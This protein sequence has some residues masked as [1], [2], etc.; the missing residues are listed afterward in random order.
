MASNGSWVKWKQSDGVELER[1]ELTKL[2]W[3]TSH[4]WL[5]TTLASTSIA[6]SDPKPKQLTVSAIFNRWRSFFKTG[7]KSCNRQMGQDCLKNCI[8]TNC[9]IVRGQRWKLFNYLW[10]LTW[11]INVQA[12]SPS[13]KKFVCD[14]KI[15]AKHNCRYSDLHAY[16][17]SGQTFK[18]SEFTLSLFSTNCAAEPGR[19]GLY[20]QTVM[21]SQRCCFYWTIMKGNTLWAEQLQILQGRIIFPLLVT[22]AFSVLLSGVFL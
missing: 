5:E 17:V 12:I 3:T 15:M 2:L 20:T 19:G 7:F 4:L 11:N 10:I 13:W 8:F 16:V 22:G 18:F 21:F 6:H 1:R 14:S 9:S